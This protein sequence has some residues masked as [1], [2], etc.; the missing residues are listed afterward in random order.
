M[1]TENWKLKIALAIC[2][3]LIGGVAQAFTI[4][5]TLPTQPDLQTGLVGHW[6][7]DG[8]DMGP[9]VRDRSGQGNHG[10]LVLGATGNTSTTT[11]PGKLGQALSF[12]GVNDYVTIP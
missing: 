6:T 10:N 8:R 7:F 9:N 11:I 2:A 5:K 1:K 4:G 3:L 12:D